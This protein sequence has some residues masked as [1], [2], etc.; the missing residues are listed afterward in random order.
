M[1]HRF[2]ETSMLNDDLGQCFMAH[3]LMFGFCLLFACH[4]ELTHCFFFDKIDTL[5]L[6]SK[7]RVGDV[8]TL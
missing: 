1:K 4:Q 5:S 2:K 7:V 8:I 6:N 3:C